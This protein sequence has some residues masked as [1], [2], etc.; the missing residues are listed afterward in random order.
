MQNG[1]YGFL[2]SLRSVEMTG[3]RVRISPLAF[4]SVEMTGEGRGCGG[5]G[6][7]A[8]ALQSK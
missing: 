8:Y 6:L 5:K 4:G 1:G 3:V 7:R 2:H